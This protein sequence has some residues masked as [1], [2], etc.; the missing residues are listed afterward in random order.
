MVHENVFPMARAALAAGTRIIAWPE[1]L[2]LEFPPE[3]PPIDDLGSWAGPPRG[4]HPRSWL[5]DVI[6]ISPLP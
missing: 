4:P 3:I 6:S 1:D 5:V 2:A